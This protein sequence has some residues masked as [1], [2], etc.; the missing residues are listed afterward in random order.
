MVTHE[1]VCICIYMYILMY[2]CICTK[3]GVALVHIA[4]KE[5]NVQ[6]FNI[7]SDI[8]RGAGQF[9]RMTSLTT[10]GVNIK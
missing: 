1:F 5:G 10:S 9:D 6:T 4:A 8:V 7:L 3:D 2:S